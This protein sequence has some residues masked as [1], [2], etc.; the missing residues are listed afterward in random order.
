MAEWD[1]FISHASEDKLVIAAPLAHVL[2]DGT[3]KVWY[4]D[5]SLHVGDSLSRTISKGLRRAE[6]GIVIL[7]PHFF[8]K[9]WPRR[10]LAVL[11]SREAGLLSS[12]LPSKRRKRIIL[13][14]WFD[15]TAN[16]VQRYAPN[17]S[18]RQ[19]VSTSSGLQA[20]AEQIV[21]ATYPERLGALPLSNV[22]DETDHERIKEDFRSL[23][24]RNPPLRDVRLFLSA[25]HALLHGI[26][27]YRPQLVPAYKLNCPVPFDFA[28]LVR[29][30]ITGPI[31]VELI[32]LGPIESTNDLPQLLN[33]IDVSLGPRQ[34]IAEHAA[35][36]YRGRPYAGEYA[37]LAAAVRQLH[38]LLNTARNSSTSAPTTDKNIHWD[39]PEVWQ[40]NFLVI[41]GRRHKEGIEDERNALLKSVGLPI[42][43]ASYD[44]LLD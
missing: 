12:L 41:A 20:V 33:D 17:L 15:V 38:S 31:L 34:Q 23:L 36:A 25:Y 4:D 10:E 35:N 21:R 19:G 32:T 2:R 14:V 27:G 28:L 29:E 43:L 8:A 37:P 7:S 39:R 24:D 26:V 13:P 16:D 44:R 6:Y 18:D 42:E 1:Y 5:F 22:M 3:F 40:V 9:A 30:G 11:T